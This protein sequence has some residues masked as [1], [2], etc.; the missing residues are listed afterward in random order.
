M[1]TKEQKQKSFT[2][3]SISKNCPLD[4]FK[5]KDHMEIEPFCFQKKFQVYE[6]RKFEKFKDAF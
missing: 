5:I 1:I 4:Q 6:E 2:Q 3:L